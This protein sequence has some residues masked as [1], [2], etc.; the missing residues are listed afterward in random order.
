M[1]KKIVTVFSFLLLLSC[2]RAMLNW[3]VIPIEDLEKLTQPLIYSGDE[4]QR[5]QALTEATERGFEL[6][7][8]Q[9]RPGARGHLVAFLHPRSTGGI[10]VEFVQA[11]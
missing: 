5:A 11:H 6:I 7:D 3:Q 8:T 9:P 1:K 4:S 2:S 10:L